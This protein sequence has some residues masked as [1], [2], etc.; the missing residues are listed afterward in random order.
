LKQRWQ[1]R[2]VVFDLDGTMVDNMAFHAEAFAVF[3]E[4]HGLPPLTESD[5]PR[6]DGKRNRDIFP[7]LFDRP[8]SEEEL[9]SYIG[10]KES[11]YRE[12]S[13]GRL[14]PLPGLIRLL[15]ALRAHGVPFGVATS[16]PPE[17][18]RHNLAELGLDEDAIPVVRS[19]EVPSGKPAPDV[20]LA[21]ARLIGVDPA[22]CLAFEDAPAGLVAATRAG[23]TCAAV[24]TGASAEQLRALG[25]PFDLAVPDFE[26]F[27]CGPGAALLD[28]TLGPG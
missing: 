14:R 3:V 20:F 1:P 21:A 13:R 25:V 23:M 22:G 4:R 2:G 15:D 17:N 5:R 26:A 11:L 12:R 7:V 28:P 18:V 10:E 24:T 9:R 16:A 8:L 27:L 19:D 6:F